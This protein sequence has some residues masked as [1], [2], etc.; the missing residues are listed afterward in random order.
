MRRDARGCHRRV[1]DMFGVSVLE[2]AQ[3]LFTIAPRTP[4]LMVR[5]PLEAEGHA[6]LKLRLGAD[7]IPTVF[8][9]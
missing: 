5:Q 7:A 6:C 2:A 8:A 1:S 4:D 9:P 3:T